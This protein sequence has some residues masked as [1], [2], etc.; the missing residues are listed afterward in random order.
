VLP[1]FLQGI[2]VDSM[3]A[4]RCVREWGRVSRLTP[5]AMFPTQRGRPPMVPWKA[6]GGAK[7]AR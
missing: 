6:Y 3:V 4:L 1:D 2:E 5:V 7:G